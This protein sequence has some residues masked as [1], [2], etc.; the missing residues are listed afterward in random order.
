MTIPL[1]EVIKIQRWAHARSFRTHTNPFVRK[2][3]VKV[4]KGVVVSGMPREL[5]DMIYGY[6]VEDPD[7]LARFVGNDILNCYSRRRLNCRLLR[8]EY[9]RF[10]HL[11]ETKFAKAVPLIHTELAE[12]FYQNTFIEVADLS[13]LDKLDSFDHFNLVAQHGGEYAA[14][15]LI[16]HLTVNISP[17][18]IAVPPEGSWVPTAPLIGAYEV[19]FLNYIDPLEG[20]TEK[21]QRSIAQDL[22]HL[23][24][25]SVGARITLNLKIDVHPYMFGDLR[26]QKFLEK[27]FPVLMR[28]RN[29]GYRIACE[30]KVS[31]RVNPQKWW[32]D[33]QNVKIESDVEFSPQGWMEAIKKARESVGEDNG[34]PA[35][36]ISE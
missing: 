13:V 16:H 7:F 32:K 15:K 9:Y 21:L 24:G 6:I 8:P 20:P 1:K 30:G 18:D 12:A 35:W 34:P 36:M 17:S 2:A 3:A 23:F 26:L 5:R 11:K 33:P 27:S 14:V 19:P 31:E 28:L 10:Q 25:L 4:C 22:E 29:A